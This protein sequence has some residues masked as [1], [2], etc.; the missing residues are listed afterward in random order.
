MDELIQEEPQ[1]LSLIGR[2]T[3][4]FTAPSETFE[5]VSRGHSWRD[6]L[7]PVLIT[8]VLAMV[9]LQITMPIIQETARQAVRERVKEMP[10][11]QRDAAVE[12]AGMATGIASYVMVPVASFVM[13]FVIGGILLLIGRFGLGG[14]V[15]YGQM[16]SVFAYS[17][18]VG[19]VAIVVRTPLMLARDTAQ[20]YTG[21]GLLVP[22]EMLKT[23]FGRL[24][25]GIDL[26]S[27]WQILVASI[28]MAVLTRTTTTRAATFLL[29]LWGIW[30]VVQAA[31]GGLGMMG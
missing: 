22:E 8:T 30:V 5:A 1:D 20:V 25:A 15:S 23:F 11:D 21:L 13:L 18:L 2:M 28:G 10:E 26:F 4:V 17:S 29:I 7:V 16:L 12:M 27:L 24:L 31:L 6:W 9:A 3:R 19:I 14:Q